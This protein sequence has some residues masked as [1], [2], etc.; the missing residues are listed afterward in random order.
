MDYVDDNET[1]FET[2]IMVFPNSNT[3]LKNNPDPRRG[4]A[5]KIVNEDVS[6]SDL[7]P[8]FNYTVAI[9]MSNVVGNSMSESTH[10][11]SL[12]GRGNGYHAECIT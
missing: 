6:I 11:I 3:M 1:L 12:P 8:F 2:N 4:V 10:V 9:Y 7:Q 5:D